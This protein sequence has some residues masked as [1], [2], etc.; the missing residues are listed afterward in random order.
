MRRLGS[1]GL[2]HILGSGE[3]WFVTYKQ[4][5]ERIDRKTRK[6]RFIVYL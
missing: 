6:V 3:G 2:L 4:N 1:S 5:C